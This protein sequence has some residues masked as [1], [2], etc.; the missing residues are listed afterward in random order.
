MKK[1]S[2]TKTAATPRKLDASI[3]AYSRA[4]TP[5]LRSICERLRAWIDA[6]IPGAMSKV[7][8][9]SPVWFVGENPVVGYST[10]AHAVRLL[11]WNG[12]AFREPDF[13]PVGKY[14]AAQA[15]ISE[16]EQLDAKAV[17]RWLKKARTYV[18][19]SK[20]FFKKLRDA[21]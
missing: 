5:A 6:E 12:Q 14:G 7:W 4:Q 13:E 3:A 19:D 2:S 20:A 8:H 21:K 10:S 18:F 15:V 11:F 16:A 9:G 1:T 17:R